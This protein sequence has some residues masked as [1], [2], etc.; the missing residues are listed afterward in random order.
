M[1]CNLAPLDGRPFG[2]LL[3]G[4]LLD[5]YD[6]VVSLLLFGGHV[7]DY[8][9]DEDEDVVFALGDVYAVGVGQGE[10]SFADGGDGLVVA[11]EVVFVVEEIALGFE[12]A[13]AGAVGID[14]YGEVVA[15]KGPDFLL[16]DG[17]ELA[18]AV[19]FVGGAPGEEFLADEGELVAVHVLE[20][21]LV[22]D[23]ESAAVDEEAVV[24]GVVLDGEVVA[25]G[26]ELLFHLVAHGREDSVW[27]GDGEERNGGCL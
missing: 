6:S 19:D 2:K 14:V 17:E 11:G 23:G 27:G 20:G 4:D 9:A 13:G 16:D 8:G 12:V 3:N 5:F 26:E 22:A 10:P 1:F 21:E 24:A 7:Y 25:E 15:E 18:V